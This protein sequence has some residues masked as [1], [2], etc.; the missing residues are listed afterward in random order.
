MP[1]DLSSHQV[2]TTWHCNLVSKSGRVL[3]KRFLRD[4]HCRRFGEA[5]F[6][7]LA[8]DFSFIVQEYFFVN[9]MT[10]PEA[11][12]SENGEEGHAT[13]PAMGAFGLDFGIDFREG[14]VKER[15][16]CAIPITQ[17]LLRVLPLSEFHKSCM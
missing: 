11:L 12:R 8:A 5:P 1:A 13:G 6:L 2:R 3:F 16:A 4:N 14:Q 7:I 9:K 10:N 15:I 17:A